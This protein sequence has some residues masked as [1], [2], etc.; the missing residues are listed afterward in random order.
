MPRRRITQADVAA[1]AG[2]SQATVSF[3]LNDRLPAGVHI[4]ADT[5][6]RVLDAIRITGYSANPAAQRLAGGRNQIIGVFT[7]EAT[8]P[9]GGRD[10]YGPFLVGIEHAAEQLGIDILLFTSARVVDGRRR[11]TRDGWQRLGIADGCLLLGQ[12]EDR[13]E[14]QHLLDTNYPFAFIGKRTSEGGR[15][16]YVGADYVAATRCAVERL[17]AVG[18]RRIGYVGELGTDQPTLDRLEGYRSTMQ[19]TTLAARLVTEEDPAATASA[20]VDQGLTALVVAPERDAEELY[21]A[22]LLRGL[23]VP[24][25]VSLLLLGQP[26]RRLRRP[27]EWSGFAIPREEMGARA[28]QLLSRLIANQ[29]LPEADLHQ[30]LDCTEVEGRTVAPPRAVGTSATTTQAP[31]GLTQITP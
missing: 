7:Y 16:P 12:H 13:S 27:H 26:Q 20:V 15:L 21:D 3:V 25:D 22:L 23:A 28:L 14:L 17:I 19:G 29:D 10:F 2:V 18:H 6:Q 5:R 31:A 4:S 8:F 30:L 24:T 11:L 1:M 9:G